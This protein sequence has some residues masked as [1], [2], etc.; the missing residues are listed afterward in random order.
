MLIVLITTILSKCD[1]NKE[2]IEISSRDCSIREQNILIKSHLLAC[3]EMIQIDCPK[4][5]M[6]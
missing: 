3:P 1:C 2:N 4:V 5:V 6:L